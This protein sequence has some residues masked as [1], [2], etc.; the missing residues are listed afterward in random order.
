MNYL[1]IGY[2]LL[3]WISIIQII[4]FFE[5][6]TKI[7][8]EVF[9]SN[10]ALTLISAWLLYLGGE[11]FA[12]LITTNPWII[13][14][15]VFIVYICYILVII[16]GVIKGFELYGQ[17]LLAFK[18][19][20]SQQI[21]N[22]L[23]LSDSFAIIGLLFLGLLNRQQF[24]FSVIVYG[25]T[26][27]LLFFTYSRSSF[28][29]FLCTTVFILIRE[30]WH[31][32]KH[33]FLLIILGIVMVVIVFAIWFN[34][35]EIREDLAGR[36]KLILDR[37][38]APF[39]GTD[40]SL[41]AR[42]LFLEEGLRLLKKH[43]LLGYYMGEV[44]EIGKGAYIHNWLS[45]WFA[46]GIGPFLVSSWLLLSLFIKNLYRKKRESLGFSESSIITFVLLSVVFSRSYIWPYFWFAISF[47][48][49][50]STLKRGT[51]NADRSPSSLE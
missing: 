11:A 2:L 24:Y 8:T 34:P 40:P 7:G 32:K 16:D 33:Q 3:T 35:I 51:V 14:K 21:Y 28:F 12:H 27:L 41:Q 31:N 9:F 50:C 49:T 4:W 13:R 23:S 10:I 19:P 5:I 46:Y 44:V 25:S 6:F 36:S 1:A 20:M 43:W 29:C 15:F 17:F 39:L 45:F 38:S 37:F 48:G 18:K 26:L 42:W 22:Y 47:S 30:V